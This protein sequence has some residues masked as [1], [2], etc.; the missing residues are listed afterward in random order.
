MDPH[1][2]IEVRDLHKSFAVPQE[3]A[4][5]WK[6]RL[7]PD[8]R[9]VAGAL[10]V[11]EGITFDVKEGEFFGITGRN[12][13]G[14]STLVRL[15]AN[16]YGADSGSIKVRG[17]VTPMVELG[18]GFNGDFSARENVVLGGVM[19]GLDRSAIEARVDEV[20]EFAGVAKY[21]ELRLSNFSSGMRTRLAF[22]VS[23]E[24]EPDILL[25]DE[26]LAVGDANFQERCIEVIEQ[27]RSR[28]ATIVIVTHSI[29]KIRQYCDR[30][31]LLVDGK[32][33]VIGNPDECAARYREVNAAELNPKALEAGF[34]V[35]SVVV[36]DGAVKPV[37]EAGEEIVGA[38]EIETRTP[39]ENVGVRIEVR[40]DDSVITSFDSE[41]IEGP[42]QPG[43]RIRFVTR[44]E[45][46]LLKGGYELVARAI[47]RKPDGG[48]LGDSGLGH[49]PF[50]VEGRSAH[51]ALIDLGHSVEAEGEAAPVGQ[52][53][54]VAGDR[55]L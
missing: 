31:L 36:G 44:I 30:A 35:A 27:R 49:A 22:A 53:G 21:S 34:R 16:I 39:Q 45:N 55:V 7:R 52:P 38:V 13:S 1:N 37:L 54:T 41:F 11:L 15:L 19:M 8:R 20:L 48:V 17:R 33:D 18:V 3:G 47:R 40:S 50:E 26:V 6:D 43:E 14:K 46:K 29:E 4:S 2:A 12:G 9:A 10:K 23:I 25:L 51:G 42:H 5:T 32:I 24:A 28:G